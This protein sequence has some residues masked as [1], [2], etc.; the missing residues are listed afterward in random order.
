MAAPSLAPT[1]LPPSSGG[2]II[3]LDGIIRRFLQRHPLWPVA[4]IVLLMAIQISTVWHPTPDVTG[5]FSIARSVWSG[6]GLSCLGNRQLHFAPAYPLVIS[7]AFLLP[8][9]T[10]LAIACLRFVLVLATLAAVYYWIR[11]L[12]PP[13]VAL[14]LTAVV[15]C[16]TCLWR[17]YRTPLADLPM[18][19]GM[20]WAA[21]AMR[22]LL[23]ARSASTFTAW[24]GA[25]A[26]LL[27]AAAFTRQSAFTLATGLVISLFLARNFI[28]RSRALIAAGV[29]CL[30]LLFGL[31]ALALRE[32]ART[33]AAAHYSYID[34]A[35][36]PGVP[37]W[38]QLGNGLHLRV[39][40]VGRLLLPGLSAARS[41]AGQWLDPN[42][43]LYLP[44]AALVAVG[45]WRLTRRHQDPLLWSMPAYVAL[46][47]FWPFDEDTRFFTPILPVLALSLWPWI[48]RL[49]GRWTLLAALCAL[50]LAFALR[51]WI[52]NSRQDAEDHRR[53]WPALAAFAQDITPQHE[54][55]AAIDTTGNTRLW[56]QYLTD[57]PVPFVR[58]GQ[59]IPA[60]RIWILEPATSV[61]PPEFVL[62]RHIDDLNLYRR[63]TAS[64]NGRR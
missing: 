30:P 2:G 43:L 18:M 19:L 57:R 38:Q 41:R 14:L 24:C 54:P 8:N 13:P 31:L 52:V 25:S 50:H 59:P 3:H 61:P 48:T 53:H 11:P 20:F 16:N 39:A 64:P 35:R 10:F 44:V 26:L 17:Y 33:T 40:E 34:L 27:A 12:A 1:T 51:G 23:A 15:A 4:G 36:P 32:Q 60:E 22:R 37:L 58:A 6:Q 47:V 9:H 62:F 56:L 7:P 28:G 45:W 63:Q 21:L 29:I 46:Y 5:Y 42:L 55:A 49:R